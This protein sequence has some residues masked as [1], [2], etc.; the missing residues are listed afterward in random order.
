M[1]TLDPLDG[2]AAFLAVATHLSFSKA[3]D[4]LGMS[5]ATMGAQVRQLEDR[6]G[7]RLFH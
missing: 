4:E 3:A 6:L 2:I 1:R 7:I 5:R